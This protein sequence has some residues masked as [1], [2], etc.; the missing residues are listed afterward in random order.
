MK[1][2]ILT[3]TLAVGLVSNSF[4]GTAQLFDFNSEAIEAEF[5]QINQFESYVSNHEGLTFNDMQNSGSLSQFDLNWNSFDASA[6]PMFGISDMDWNAAV[7]GFCCWPIG[8][9]TVIL[10]DNKDSDSKISYLIGVGVSL[11]ASFISY[12]GGIAS[13]I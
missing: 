3:R 7:C 11:V 8:I 1:Y 6:A 9:F 12:L 10:N 5:N 2:F 13:S 4:A